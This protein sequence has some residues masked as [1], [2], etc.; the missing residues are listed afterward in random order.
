MK[1]DIHDRIFLNMKQLLKIE[2]NIFI[3]LKQQRNFYYNFKSISFFITFH[4]VLI[5]ESG[6]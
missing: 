3:L 4:C 1:S 6:I 2:N 5:L